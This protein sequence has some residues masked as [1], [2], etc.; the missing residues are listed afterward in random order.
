MKKLVREIAREVGRINTP[1][2]FTFDTHIRKHPKL[3]MEFGGNRRVLAFSSSPRDEQAALEST[4]RQVRHILRD[5][6][7]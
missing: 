4:M 2:A 5:M 3:V 1:A 6:G 7:A